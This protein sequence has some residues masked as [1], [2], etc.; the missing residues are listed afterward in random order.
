MKKPAILVL[1]DGTV[2]EGTGFGAESVAF[3]ELVFNTSMS[4]YQEILS[5]PSYAG[6]IVTL[7]MPH[8]GNYGTNESDLESDGIKA[9]GLVVR[10]LTE[11]PSNWQSE[12]GLDVWLAAGGVAAIS[13]IDTRSLTRRL[14]DHGVIAAAIAPGRTRADAGAVLEELRAQPDYGD[15]DWVRQVASREP[16]TVTLQPDGRRLRKTTYEAPTSGPHVVVLDFGVKYSIVRNLLERGLAVTLVGPDVT[17]ADVFDLRPDGVLVSNGPGDPAL[18]ST[19]ATRLLD[20]AA[21]VPTWG[22]CLGHQLLAQAFGATTYKLDFGHR[23]PNQPVL[24]RATGRVVITSQNHGFAVDA[25]TVPDVLEITQHNLNDDTVEAFRHKTLDVRAVQYHPEAG[26]GP[27]DA[28]MFF[29]EFRD[30][31]APKY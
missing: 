20:L 6:Q 10:S 5:D 7:T 13:E 19:A 29:D 1:A 18:L 27:H 31:L 24:D 23:G 28:A 8:I 4:G 11:R 9:S 14:R 16:T 15:V 21:E 17:A 12:Q 25:E 26:P 3:G 2:L 30:V 22:I